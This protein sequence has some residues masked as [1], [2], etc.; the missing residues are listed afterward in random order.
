MNKIIERIFK[1]KKPDFDRLEEYGFKTEGTSCKFTTT[2]LD[3]QFS[4]TVKVTAD[5]VETT[6]TDLATDEPYTLF[7]A[8]GAEGGFV[9][10][11]RS[12]YEKVLKDIAQNCFDDFIFKS[13]TSQAVIKYVGEKYGDRLEFLWEKFSDNAVWRR[14]DNKKWYA[15]MLTVP[16]SKLGLNSDEKVEIIDLRADPERIEGMVD[17]KKIFG[18][19]HM[20]KKHWITVCL[21]G[22]LPPEDICRMIDISYNLAK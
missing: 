9:V 21:D 14:S 8:D 5:G 4:L 6:V 7:L 16:K 3:G 11:V 1:N 12:A 20:N 18:G 19:W 10:S 22:S 15:V 2:I 17:G 13:E